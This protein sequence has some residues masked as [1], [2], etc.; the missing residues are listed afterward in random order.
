MSFVEL[1]PGANH[2]QAQSYPLGH[3]ELPSNISRL[4]NRLAGETRSSCLTALAGRPSPLEPAAG[5]R[6]IMR[7]T[8]IPRGHSAPIH[9][10]P[11][12]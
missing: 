10:T 7:A 12:A 3:P 1:G 8:D 2:G 6:Q 11:S 5:S 4:L 9:R